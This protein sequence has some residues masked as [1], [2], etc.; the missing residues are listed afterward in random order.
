MDVE[1]DGRGSDGEGKD[2]GDG[3]DLITSL[4]ST[5]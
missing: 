3:D 1:V 2:E 4:S 5:R